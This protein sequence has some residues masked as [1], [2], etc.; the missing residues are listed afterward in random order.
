MKFYV[1]VDAGSTY[2]KV[3]ILD[4]KGYLAGYNCKPTGIDVAETSKKIINDIITPLKLTHN[5]IARIAATGYGR[6][7]IDMADETVTEI[8]AHAAGAIWSM[9]QEAKI[10]SVID[11][12]GQDSKIILIDERGEPENF[13][14]NDK[15]AAGTGRFLESLAK[16]L[17]LDVK[18]LGT[19][20]LMSKA[21]SVINSTC[22][23]F[24]ESEVISL[25]ARRNKREDIVAG[26]HQSLAKRISRMARK[27]RILPEVLLTGGGGLNIG[28]VRSLEDEL[29]KIVHIPCY[30]Q[31][32][33]A[34]GAAIIARQRAGGSYAAGQMA[35]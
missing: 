14:M 29:G 1:G 30:P 20:S 15:C 32:N 31:L 7:L 5:S 9:P 26:I 10:R 21:P 6:R 25:M 28:F 35:K 11:I 34:I 24:A 3:T 33:G 4:E 16:V 27:A 17:E 19:I 2:I 8:K 23:V 12:G 18:D 13:V 22:V